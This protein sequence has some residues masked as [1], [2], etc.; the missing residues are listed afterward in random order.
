M[1]RSLYNLWLRLLPL[2]LIVIIG[3]VGMILG[4]TVGLIIALLN[5]GIERIPLSSSRS[6]A[7]TPEPPPAMSQ[8]FTPEVQYWKPWILKWSQQY[9]VDANILATVIQIESC[10]QYMVGSSAGAQGLFQVMPFH[11]ED[12]EDMKD[13]D[14]NALRGITYLKGGLELAD[15]HIGLAMAG[16]NGG[17]GVIDW[18]WAGWYDE[19]RRYYVWGSGIYMDALLNKKTEDSAALQDWLSAGGYRL[20]DQAHAI[21]FP[22]TPTPS[23]TP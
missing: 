14:T 4:V 17:W 1:T 13:P 3:S 21:L 10:G 2:Q 7:A 12:G 20:C 23:P 15:G 5:G 16:Y 18:G 9:G 19:T 8:V 6:I 22:A 11:F